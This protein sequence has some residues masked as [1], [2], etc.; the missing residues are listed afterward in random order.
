MLH[1]QTLSR[2][3]TLIEKIFALTGGPVGGINGGGFYA[4]R[5]FIMFHL[6]ES[7]SRKFVKVI[8]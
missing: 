6:A 1:R 7:D 8:N 3:E 5:P 2:Q 4:S